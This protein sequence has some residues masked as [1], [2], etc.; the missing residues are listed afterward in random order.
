MDQIF[1]I[2]QELIQMDWTTILFWTLV[3]AAAI[4]VIYYLFVYLRIAFHKETAMTEGK[5]PVSIVICARNEIANL[6][7]NLPILLQQ[8][9]PNF[10][11]VIVND[12]SFDGTR[13][14]LDDLAE[15]NP[16]IKPVHL[17]IDERYLKGKK[18]AL[19]IGIKAAEHERMLL[20]DADC[21]PLSKDWISEMTSNLKDSQAMVLGVSFYEFNYRPINFISRIEAFHT[22][23]QYINFALA[24]APYMGVGRNIAYTQ[25]LF[26]DNKGFASHQHLVSGDDD[27][28]VNEVSSKNNIAIRYNYD[29]QT[30]SPAKIGLG[31]YWKQKS[32]HFS[33]AKNYKFKHKLM[34]FLPAFSLFFF[35]LS[36][37]LLLLEGSLMFETLIIIG[38]RLFIQWIVVGINLAKF[39]KLNNIWAVP[40]WD[41][42]LLF[43]QLFIGLKGVFSKPKTW[44]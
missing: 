13:D 42:I 1:A 10:E 19:T 28:F 30:S 24:K 6:K 15:A 12:S 38:G 3:G 41:P 35:W 23:M 25:K 31:A 40:F 9:H 27:L 20:T 39:G 11:I 29:S 43:V 18:F 8:G 26:F 17:E 7:K 16:K 44:K 4:Q 2:Q 36:A 33:S 22:A 21:Q 34:L 32:R 5:E 37:I 14:Y